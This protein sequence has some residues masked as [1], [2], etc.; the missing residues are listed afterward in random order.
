VETYPEQLK[1]F[2]TD[3]CTSLRDTFLRIMNDAFADGGPA[4]QSDEY[5]EKVMAAVGI[6]KTIGTL[7]LSVDASREVLEQLEIVVAPMIAHCFHENMSDL[8]EEMFEIIDTCTYCG[9]T[10]SPTM[11]QIFEQLYAVFKTEDGAAYMEDMLPC[12]ENYVAYGG[13]A[14]WLDPARTEK[15]YDICQSAMSNEDLTDT[16]LAAGCQLIE[17]ILLSAKG[18][19]D[20]LIPRFLKLAFDQMTKSEISTLTLVSSLGVVINA[21]YYN[22]QLTLQLLDHA[23]QTTS[24]FTT[25][26]NTIPKFTRLHDRK[27][28]VMAIAKLITL[29]TSAL[30][31]TIQA[32]RPQI[33]S[34]VL[35]LFRTMPEAIETYRQTRIL[36]G[37]ESGE[38]EDQDETDE[39]FA[40]PV[41]DDDP[42][43]DVGG[44]DD[45]D[46]LDQIDVRCTR[47]F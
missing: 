7:I 41:E 40:G 45:D 22:P 6:L 3:L 47:I 32:A 44:D 13:D 2:A 36:Y 23:G 33:V 29:P 46:Y 39:T 35:E 31:A 15:I 14:L 12:L 11:W 8:Y 34:V 17:R 21:I 43:G 16:D 37:L 25:W 38:E 27:L 19:V 42:D 18:R 9:K 5:T 1:P 24:F 10:I 20:D 28:S 26:F 30:P 4:D